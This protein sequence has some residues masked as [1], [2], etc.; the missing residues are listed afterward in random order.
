VPAGLPQSYSE[1]PVVAQDEPPFD[2]PGTFA[3]FTTEPLAKDLDLAGVPALTVAL[4]KAVPAVPLPDGAGDL[5]L[6]AKL[7]DI[8]PDGT[9]KLQHR[10]VSAARISSF[11]EPV[12]IELPGVVQR[13]PAGH[14]L[15]VVQ[16]AT[17]AT[18]ATPFPV[19]SPSRPRRRGRACWSCRCSPGCRVPPLPRR[20]PGGRRLLSRLLPRRDSCRRPARPRC[21][22]WPP[23]CWSAQA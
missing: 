7:Y 12:R 15:A 23:R 9:V 1:Y 21:C 3:Q 6:F 20:L 14:R 11:D 16:P 5:V 22:R 4:S 17:P 10:L 8:A 18:G 13:F 2:A 19:T